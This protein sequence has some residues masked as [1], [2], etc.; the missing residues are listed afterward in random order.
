MFLMSARGT[1]IFYVPQ[2]GSY[3]LRFTTWTF[4]SHVTGGGRSLRNFTHPFWISF[5]LEVLSPSS[6]RSFARVT[7][8][9]I[10]PHAFPYGLGRSQVLHGDKT[11][12]IAPIST[13]DP[14]ILHDCKLIFIAPL[15]CETSVGLSL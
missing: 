8:L 5:A 1:P 14:I 6:R 4:I 10:F 12:F 9:V 13:L 3:S 11:I 7:S 15:A 2:G